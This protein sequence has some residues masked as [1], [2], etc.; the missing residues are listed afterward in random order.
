[1]TLNLLNRYKIT[2]IEKLTW[3]VL[4]PNNEGHIIAAEEIYKFLNDK[5]ILKCQ[6]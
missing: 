2:G 4:H 6:K 1:M 5:S 3:D